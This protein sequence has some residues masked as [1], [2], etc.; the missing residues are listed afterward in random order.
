[1]RCLM[2]LIVYREIRQRLN[3]EKP[4]Q[5]TQPGIYGGRA[6]SGV[7]AGYTE[8]GAVATA[9]LSVSATVVAVCVVATVPVAFAVYNPSSGSP[10]DATGAVTVTCTPGTTYSMALDAGANPSA[11]GDVT[12]RRLKAN[13][14]D[15]LPYQLYIDVGRTTTVWGDGANGSS[16]NPTSGSYTATGSLQSYDVYGRITTGN[17]V[18]TGAYLDTVVVTVTH[19]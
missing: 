5:N 14:S 4:T 10:T 1:M 3:L 15:Y 6:G 17:Y 11:A 7:G 9:N 13:T 18:A 19:I 8:D 2:T 16:V 12:T